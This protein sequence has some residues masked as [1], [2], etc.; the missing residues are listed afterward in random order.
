MRIED[1]FEAAD[2]GY[3]IEARILNPLHDLR[4]PEAGNVV[5]KIDT[6]FNGP[7]MVTGDIFE[8]L[9]FSDIEV[10]DDIRPTYGTLAGELTMRSAPALL[11]VQGKQLETDILTPLIGPSRMLVGFQIIRELNLALL[12]NKTCLVR[13]ET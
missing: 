5:F 2:W 10:P 7:A 3:V 12:G 13:L 6:G 1:C 4:F 9:R 11:E 8:F